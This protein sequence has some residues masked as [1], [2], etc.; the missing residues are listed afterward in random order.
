MSWIAAEL[1]RES[2]G[3]ATVSSLEHAA[4]IE[5][6]GLTPVNAIIEHLTVSEARLRTVVSLDNG[7][8]VS[9]DFSVAG[10]P[11]IYVRGYVLAR[12]ASGTRF[13]YRIRLERLSKME[14]DELVR[15]VAETY[16]R[17]ARSRLQDRVMQTITTTDTLVRSNV[18]VPAQFPIFFRTARAS[19]ITAKAQDVSRGGLSITCSQGLLQG[20]TIELR[21]TLPSEPL[22]A[23]PEQTAI[24]D[25]KTRE[26]KRE[27]AD[28][29]RPF[30]EMVVRARVVS[31]RTIERGIYS[32]GV[33]FQN[34]DETVVGEI[35]R[36]VDAVELVKRNAER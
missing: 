29:R 3:T 16:R 11:T 4:T 23:Y 28:L 36:Y 21:F 10:H 14:S 18:R 7:D 35:G 13:V 22:T 30:E 25:L 6:H 9:F 27:R 15:A 34:L 24:L 12:T 31:Q 20:E 19:A 2:G 17:Q 1:P 26:V 32:Y 8:T 5:A 33:A